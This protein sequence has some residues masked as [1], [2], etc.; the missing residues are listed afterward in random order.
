MGN[1]IT[2]RQ[3]SSSTDASSASKKASKLLMLI[4]EEEWA[5]A[6]ARLLDKPA[7]VFEWTDKV[8]FGFERRVLPIH[9]ACT[10]DPPETFIQT[11][12]D[13][14]PLSSQLL[15]SSLSSGTEEDWLPLQIAVHFKAS[16]AVIEALLVAFPKAAYFR[17]KAG[18]LPIHTVC[19]AKLIDLKDNLRLE[20]GSHAEIVE[21]LLKAY[22]ECWSLQS[23]ANMTAIDYVN[24]SN[25]PG[26][27]S[28][29]DI[30][31]EKMAVLE[32]LQRGTEYYMNNPLSTEGSSKLMISQKLSSALEKMNTLKSSSKSIKLIELIK[33]KNWTDAIERC[34][35]CPREAAIWVD[36][37]EYQS[38]RLALHL[39]C[40]RRSPLELIKLLTSAYP[41]AIFCRE[42][43]GML[44]FHVSVQRK[45]DFDTLIHLASLHPASLWTQDDFGLLPLHIS[46][47]FNASSAVVQMLLMKAPDTIYVRDNRGYTAQMYTEKSLSPNRE[48]ILYALCKDPN[49][50]RTNKLQRS[51]S[52]NGEMEANRSLYDL[53]LA[54][55]WKPAH[56]RILS[57]PVEATILIKGP[58]S[59]G[60]LPLHACFERNP[61]FKI[62]K[63]LHDA[64]PDGIRE[65]G[66]YE[67]LPLHLALQQK[68]DEKIILFLINNFP[69]GVNMVDSFGRLPIIVGCLFGMTESIL[70]LL[71]RL[72]PE[73]GSLRDSS[74]ETPTSYLNMSTHKNRYTLVNIIKREKWKDEALE[75]DSEDE[76]MDN[77]ISGWELNATDTS[78]NENN[79]SEK[80]RDQDD[81]DDTDDYLGK[82]SS[83]R[84]LAKLNAMRST[85][86]PLEKK[87][88]KP[89]ATHIKRRANKPTHLRP[90]QPSIPEEKGSLK[91]DESL[92]AQSKPNYDDTSIAVSELSDSLAG[93]FRN[94][95]DLSIKSP[96]Q[97]LKSDWSDAHMILHGIPPTYRDLM[98]Q[99]E[100]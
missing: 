55:D 86:T 44:P 37:E 40:D 69:E 20:K 79:D 99:A 12:L 47:A 92:T 54:C 98:D 62:V 59:F 30:L 6:K 75:E 57:Y 11:L 87:E 64:N 17:N 43:H 14:Y 73:S 5:M 28:S 48:E 51:F 63:A 77:Y 58:D 9:L 23:E 81:T 50:W 1:S 3:Y 65:S 19:R 56:E 45:G 80:M 26:F 41:D 39:A 70:K 95:R 91:L 53:I 49:F 27:S 88:S 13:V 66:K 67:M 90:V 96:A 76:I 4:E 97:F 38:K 85:G 78:R 21:L 18:R 22:P 16:P 94:S 82:Y 46:C 52:N 83:G 2:T 7:E 71:L 29:K 36:D 25:P 34:T 60:R 31:E 93:E 10:I 15:T 68:C 84:R 89:K 32:V 74:G 24:S 61:P 42:K 35:K 72:Y 33:N 100:N 8:C